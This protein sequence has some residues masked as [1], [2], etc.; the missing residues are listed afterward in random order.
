MTLSGQLNIYIWKEP[1]GRFEVTTPDR[2]FDNISAFGNTKLKALKEFFILM[3][4]ELE[5]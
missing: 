5:G 3:L 2:P 1:D 4:I